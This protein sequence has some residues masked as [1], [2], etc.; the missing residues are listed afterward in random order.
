MR[1]YHQPQIQARRDI[2]VGLRTLMR[3]ETHIELGVE[4]AIEWLERFP[5]IPKGPE[6]ELID[7]LIR[8]QRFEE[9]RRV[10]ISRVDL[11]DGGRRRNWDV[12]GLIVDFESTVSRLASSSVE[13]E[14]IWYLRDRTDGRSDDGAKVTFTPVQLEWFITTFRPLWPMV[15]HPSRSTGDTNSW[16]ASEYLNQL[17]SRLGN[18]P[19]EDAFAALNRLRNALPDGYTSIIQSVAAEQARVR[20]EIAYTSPTL[21]AINAVTRDRAPVEAADMQALMMEELEV[22]QAKIRSDD[23]ESWRG[24]YDDSGVPFDEERC[25]DHLLGLLRQASEGITLDPETHVAGDREVDITCSVG[26]LR[27]PIEIKGQW[28]R[29]LWHA[30]DSQL[31]RLYTQDWRAGR[32]GIY[33]VLWFGQHQPTNKCLKSPGRDRQRPQTPDQLREMLTADSKAVID[34]RIAVFVLDLV[35]C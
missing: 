8:S 26:A 18:D 24:F 9:L 25:R 3:D 6:S 15:N 13:P 16:D 1:L 28:H 14:L 4:C 17:I 22:V 7:R 32:N 20:V 27:M 11:E 21:A 10:A 2:V 35:R 23:A 19:S 31:D 12:I 34:G 29:D 30:A 33:L 5:D